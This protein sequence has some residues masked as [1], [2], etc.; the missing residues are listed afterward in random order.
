MINKMGGL[1]KTSDAQKMFH[2]LKKDA[3]L[4]KFR[5]IILFDFCPERVAVD[6]KNIS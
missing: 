4:L 5:K 1:R 6:S 2:A 3:R